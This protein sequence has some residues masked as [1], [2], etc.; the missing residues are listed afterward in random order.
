MKLIKETTLL[1]GIAF[2]LAC[3]V[4]AQSQDGERKGPPSSEEIFEKMDAN[5]DNL[6]EESEI[7]GPLKNDFDTVDADGDGFITKEELDNAPKPERKGRQGGGR[8]Q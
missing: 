8:Q 2:L 6:L 3:N 4:N 7:K 1:S 5:K